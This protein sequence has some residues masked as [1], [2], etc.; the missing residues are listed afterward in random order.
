MKRR[1]PATKRLRLEEHRSLSNQLIRK[2]MDPK[3]PSI[4]APGFHRGSMAG[5]E[6]PVAWIAA[7]GAGSVSSPLRLFSWVGFWRLQLGV[8]PHCARVFIDD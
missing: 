5:R 3:P 1:R 4:L 2:K 8:R 7:R 6:A